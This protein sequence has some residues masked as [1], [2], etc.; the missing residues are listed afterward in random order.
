MSA[1]AGTD[2]TVISIALNKIQPE[3]TN[4]IFEQIPFFKLLREG[5]FV[6][7]LD[8]GERINHPV[9]HAVNSTAKAYSGYGILDTTP[10]EGIGNVEALWKQYSVSASVSGKERRQVSGSARIVDIVKA[11]NDQATM[12]LANVL[13]TDAF[14]TGTASDDELDGIQHLVQD[15]PTGSVVVQGIN[16]STNAWWRNQTESGAS[17]STAFDNLL[18]KMRAIFNKCDAA[19]KGLGAPEM[20][21]T[22]RTVF[23][24][25][26]GLVDSQRQYGNEKLLNLGFVNLAFKTA[27]VMF[28][29]DCP[30]GK[31]YALNPKTFMLSIH[32][33]ANM[34]VTEAVKPANQDAIVWQYLF[35][36][37]LVIRNRANNGVIHSIT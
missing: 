7:I 12:S 21:V 10:Q 3:I 32:R 36:G 26:E 31:M 35:Q 8:G 20:Y 24:G 14:S 6:K 15:T 33:D 29:N 30:S 9:M 5:G 18:S 23:E 13:N 34:S 2:I 17:S 16:Q 37:N 27:G 1:L 28:D 11:K 22:T 4:N 19:A 25:Y